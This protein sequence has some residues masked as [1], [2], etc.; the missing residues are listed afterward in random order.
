VTHPNPLEDD[1]RYQLGVISGKLDL[2]L[3]NQAAQAAQTD[4]RFTKVEARQDEA[5]DAISGLQRDRAWI[6]G[7]AAAIG[8]GL[9]GF[10]TWLGCR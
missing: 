1:S 4:A 7:G 6:L 2:I 8:A 9:S 5:E 10:A 3:V